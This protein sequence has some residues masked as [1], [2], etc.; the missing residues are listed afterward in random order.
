MLSERTL[1]Y[2][3]GRPRIAPVAVLLLLAALYRFA[4]NLDWS[5]VFP[6][7][8]LYALLL[9]FGVSRWIGYLMLGCAIVAMVALFA[10]D[11]SNGPQDPRSDRDDQLEWATRGFIEGKNPW[12]VLQPSGN[13]NSAGPA[14]VLLA[15]VPIMLFDRINE[16]SFAFNL[17][18][19]LLLLWGDLRYR[20]ES[21]PLLVFLL[22]IGPFSFQH[23]L[24]MSLSELYYGYVF[25]AL[26]W[27]MLERNCWVWAGAFMAVP[28]ALR[29]SYAFPVAGFLLWYL[30]G[31]RVS[32][33]AILR[34]AAGGA[35]CFVVVM[36]PFAM[37]LGADLLE[38]HPMKYPDVLLSLNWP[39]SNLLFYL[40]NRFGGLV[41]GAG[42]PVLSVVKVVVGLAGIWFV[43]KR[44]AA[45]RLEHP[46]WHLAFGGF[47][48][49]MLV[50]LPLLLN[51]YLPFFGVPAFLAVAFSKRNADH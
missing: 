12:T 20:N 25:L 27:F 38:N 21:F 7:L 26:A 43:S 13:P 33:A 50:Y 5:I 44:L 37:V 8:L 15:T 19:V 49:T 4:A 24:F 41:G 40:A 1:A 35:A 16:L 42:S 23:T 17:I 31:P 30:Y 47:V 22:L 34:L 29:P 45:Y 14:A 32:R 11:L 28:L 51:D 3:R 36:T 48:A 6:L 18:V 10:F 46:F 2:L 9:F 39:E